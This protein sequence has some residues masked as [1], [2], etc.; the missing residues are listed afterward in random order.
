MHVCTA[1]VFSWIY[2]LD[3]KKAFGLVAYIL[4]TFGAPKISIPTLGTFFLEESTPGTLLV[5]TT[6][7]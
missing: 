1:Y 7:A 6:Q 3:K 5:G 2:R 4:F